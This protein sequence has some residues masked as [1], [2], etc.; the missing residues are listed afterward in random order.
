MGTNFKSSVIGLKLKTEDLK[1]KI[2]SIKAI[3]IAY[4]QS[5]NNT[6]QQGVNMMNAVTSTAEIVQGV[7]VVVVVVV[8]L[9]FQSFTFCFHFFTRVSTATIVTTK[10]HYIRVLQK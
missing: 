2:E 7:V 1:N 10:Q 3:Q 8:F 4:M 9:F 6:I 5:I